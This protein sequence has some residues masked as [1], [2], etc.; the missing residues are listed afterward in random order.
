M[1]NCLFIR[2]ERMIIE[3]KSLEPDFRQKLISDKDIKY[4]LDYDV[5][6]EQLG[7]MISNLVEGKRTAVIIR[8]S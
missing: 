7:R 1:E 3:V 8:R 2:G 5:S 4:Q 6:R